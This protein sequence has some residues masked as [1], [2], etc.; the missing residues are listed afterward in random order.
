M[1]DFGNLRESPKKRMSFE[2]RYDFGVKEID[3]LN[4]PGIVAYRTHLRGQLQNVD[5]LLK[6]DD[7][8]SNDRKRKYFVELRRLVIKPL[9]R[10]SKMRM[11][12]IN[13][14]LHNGTT[15]SQA[16]RFID[17]AAEVLPLEVFQRIYGLT[18]VQEAKEEETIEDV[19]A[20]IEECNMRLNSA[21]NQ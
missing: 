4:I 9:L 12:Q 7:V 19:R 20:F 14:V 2:A 15:K 3:T 13:R 17:I 5:L 21:G 1:E 16:A 6:E 10:H 8:Q 11:K 18:V